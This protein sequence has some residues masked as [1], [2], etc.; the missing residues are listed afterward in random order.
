MNEYIGIVSLAI[1]LI[2]YVIFLKERLIK[3]EERNSIE[4]SYSIRIIVVLIVGIILLIYQKI[5]SH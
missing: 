5:K 2:V 4:K 1:I 3:W